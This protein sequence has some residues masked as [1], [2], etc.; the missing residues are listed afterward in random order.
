MAEWIHCYDLARSEPGFVRWKIERRFCVCEIWSVV[1][2]KLTGAIQRGRE[3]SE[4]VRLICKIWKIEREF[5]ETHAQARA[6]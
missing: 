6:L 5:L 4:R 1:W 3:K 2:V